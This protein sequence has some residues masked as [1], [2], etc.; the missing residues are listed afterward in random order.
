MANTE[1]LNEERS[2]NIF[3]PHWN[4][5]QSSWRRNVKKN[6]K[7]RPVGT[8][9]TR[10]FP[11]DFKKHASWKYP[12][13]DQWKQVRH[14]GAETENLAGVH[15]LP[16]CF[17]RPPS[18]LTVEHG[19][20]LLKTHSTVC[21]IRSLALKHILPNAPEAQALPKAREPNQRIFAASALTAFDFFASKINCTADENEDFFF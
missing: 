20:F 12:S 8:K 1:K 2:I 5:L 17:F 19:S 18:S 13:W 21:A 3:C 9:G 14:L 10:D 11:P 4:E 6:P 7:Q 16:L 15:V